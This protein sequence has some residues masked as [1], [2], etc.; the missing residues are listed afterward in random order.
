M[1]RKMP[2]PRSRLEY[3]PFL[4]LSL[5]MSMLVEMWEVDGG[6]EGYGSSRGRYHLR[7]G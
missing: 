3:C 6:W 2:R 5:F 4:C 7:F 1:G